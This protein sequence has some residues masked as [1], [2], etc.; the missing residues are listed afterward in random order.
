MKFPT[1]YLMHGGGDDDT[2]FQRMSRVEFY[3]EQNNVM[4]VTPQVK[5]S[6]FW[7]QNMGFV[8]LHILRKNCLY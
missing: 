7:I 3:A 6:F 1:V 4:T 2:T 8:I 5:D